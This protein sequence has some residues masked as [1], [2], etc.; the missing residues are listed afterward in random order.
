VQKY[1]KLNDYENKKL[2]GKNTTIFR[3]A[4]RTRT[5]CALFAFVVG[6]VVSLRR[7]PKQSGNNERSKW[8]LAVPQRRL[9]Q[10]HADDADF[11]DLR[12]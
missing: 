4:I 10:K 9:S 5:W 8:L 6:G 7:S 2:L 3:V 1:E 11:K 12:R